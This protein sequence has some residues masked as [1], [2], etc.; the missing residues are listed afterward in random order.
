MPAPAA[1]ET[2]S[3]PIYPPSLL[4]LHQPA[5]VLPRLQRTLDRPN[6][7]SPLNHMQN[8]T[9]NIILHPLAMPP[10]EPPHTR[11][12]IKVLPQPTDLVQRDGAQPKLLRDLDVEPATRVRERVAV[13]A[14]REEEL[15]IVGDDFTDDADDELG[16]EGEQ[17]E[18][19]RLIRGW[20]LAL[21]RSAG[22]GHGGRAGLLE[23]QVICG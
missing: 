17:G 16:G 19:G 22:S 11:P 5:Q 15:A 18:W 14:L 8:P 20:R 3:Q 6:L 9:P 23:L 21:Q 1:I 13:R 4:P 2:D 12:E 7:P 10:S